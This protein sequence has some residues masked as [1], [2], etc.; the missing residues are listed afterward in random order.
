MGIKKT[1]TLYAHLSQNLASNKYPLLNDEGTDMNAR[2]KYVVGQIYERYSVEDP[3]KSG[4]R[5]MREEQVKAICEAGGKENMETR[6]KNLMFWADADGV[7]TAEAFREFCQKNLL[8]GDATM[9]R[10]TLFTKLGYRTDLRKEPKPGDSD[11]FMQV[12]DVD[13]MPRF[14]IANNK[15]Y[16]DLLSKLPGL[17]DWSGSAKT[18][19]EDVADMLCT[20]KKVLS[21]VLWLHD[22]PE[23]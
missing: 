17:H 11:D 20:N 7:V 9:T 12:R 23:G 19:I 4:R 1:M 3:E 16:F 10:L 15:A 14:K 8:E 6:V 2:A 18:V 21:D 22:R 13:Q 5:V